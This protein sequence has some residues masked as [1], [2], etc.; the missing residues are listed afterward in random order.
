[1]IRV[2]TI[3]F[4]SFCLFF[5]NAHALNH[6]GAGP[7]PSDTLKS[8]SIKTKLLP[9]KYF[10]RTKHL[11][12]RGNA[13]F[14]NRLFLES[15]PYLLQHAHNP[16]NWYPWGDAAFK[17][18]Q[19]LGLPVLLSIGYSTCHWCH[20]M[21]EE[22][23]ENLII[24]KYL[25]ENYIAIK[26]DRE[27]RPDVDSVYMKAVQAL[28]GSGGWPMTMWLTPTKSP[29]YGATY[30]PPFDGDRGQ[31][32][33]FLSMLKKIKTVYHQ[34]PKKIQKSSEQ[35]SQYI[36]NSLSNNSI[37]KLPDTKPIKMTIEYFMSQFDPI[38]GGVNRA[39]KFP[40][41][42]PIRLILRHNNKTPQKKLIT[43][44]TTTLS[45]MS[46]GGMYDH[47]AGGFHRYS[48]DK[49]WLVPHFEKMLYD[50]A[51]LVM[52]YNEAYLATKNPEYKRVAIEILDYVLR[53]MT[54]P[55]SGAFYS[56]TDA[57]SI[58]PLGEREE[59]YFFT[60]TQKELSKVLTPNEK[61]LA[62][63][64]YQITKAGNFENNRTILSRAHTLKMVAK[65]MKIPMNKATRLL[66]SLREKLYQRRKLRPPPLRDEKII[67]AWNGLMISAFATSGHIYN[68]QKYLN[69]AKKAANYMLKN[70]FVKNQLKRI[71]LNG[72][73]KLTGYLDDYSFLIAA[74]L[75]LYE[76]SSNINWMKSAMHLDQ[77]LEDSYED[78]KYG[79]Y[80]LTPHNHELLI[81]RE[82]P[83]YDGAIP[84]G[85]SI[86][87]MNLLRLHEFTSN[88]N[89]R[90][91]A[92]SLFK[93]SAKTLLESPI[94]VT[95]LLMAL[96][97]K[98]SSP[99]EIIIV[100]PK[101]QRPGDSRIVKALK[102]TYYPNKIISIVENGKQVK[103]QAMT[104][105][106]LKGKFSIGNKATAFICQAGICKLPTNNVKT[107]LNQLNA[108]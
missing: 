40:S 13:K 63:Q 84:S 96:K 16:V 34:D 54:S 12:S 108:N 82:K 5:T 47:I 20:V 57:D 41:S 101:G 24:A 86:Q 73:T 3:L 25:N 69:A 74:L 15:S 95:H 89:Y 81:A 29:I 90:K 36:I 1:M 43:M 103:S 99:K 65:K 33:G 26:V 32:I 61:K 93:N 66:K 92:N 83:S 105:P 88:D 78:K 51:Q 19:Q 67:T 46:R 102:Q 48:T 52:D 68:N 100:Y 39:P 70:H 17:K 11:D 56:A 50:N 2:S 55:S 53:D 37:G 64:L 106:L 38:Y 79:G 10:P 60:W 49:K 72:N 8:I 35:L 98:Y 23:F 7:L 87:A 31:R 91:R 30:M 9:K 94:S 107:F 62:T 45:A 76:A 21:E 80:F 59:G 71:S 44:A 14:T 18:A 75:D 28:K 77:I 58:G 104:L 97:F 85:N 27:E 4:Y 42:F 6:P 22:S